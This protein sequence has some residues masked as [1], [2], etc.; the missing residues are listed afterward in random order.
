M[1]K[2]LDLPKITAFSLGETSTISQLWRNWVKSLEY[3]I[4][5]S[6][7]TEK[8]QQRAIPLHLAG[9][10][11]Q[12]IFE[13]LEDTGNDLDTAITKL[14]AYFEPRKDI[15]FERHNFRQTKQLQGE[16]IEQFAIRLKHQVKFCEYSSPDDM[17]RDQVIEQCL[18][19]RLRRRLLREPE[20]TLEK[21]IEIGR[22][23]EASERQASQMEAD[24]LKTT[25]SNLG[26]NAIRSQN[27]APTFPAS[28]THKQDVRI[29]SVIAVEMQVTEL[30]TPVALPKACLVTTATNVGIL[31][32]YAVNRYP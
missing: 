30:K 9:P 14:T 25:D 22:S 23:F 29:S 28:T 5:A 7:I 19:S 3:Y 13:T 10:E 8:K 18:S 12:D 11:V 32:E 24:S 15:P 31:L 26:V 27:K 1:A 20:L 21:T 4:A 16:T 6:G 17:I 2:V